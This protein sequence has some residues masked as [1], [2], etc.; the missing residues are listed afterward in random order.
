[1]CGIAGILSGPSAPPPALDQ[2]HD[3]AAMLGHRGPDGYGLYR[4]AQVGLA[5][6]R[7]SLI[8]L[9]GGFQPIHNGAGTTWLCFNGEI[10]NYVELRRHLTELGHQ[11]YTEGDSEVIVQCYERYGERCWEMLNGQFAFALWDSARQLLWLVRDRLGILPLHYARV[12]DHVVFA[13]E[14]KALFASGLVAPRFDPA[15]LAQVFTFW[16]ATAPQTVFESVRMV[17]PATALRFDTR[18]NE[19]EARYWQPD[20]HRLD[21]GALGRD[22][23]VAALEQQ[24][25]QSISLRLRADLP[26]G[27]YVSGGL[28]SAVIASLAK[29]QVGE[30]LETFGIG[31]DDPRF[32]ETGDQHQV[33]DFL[34]T[35]HHGFHCGGESIRDALSDVTWH[36][37]TPMLR[38][39]PVPLYLLARQVR[40]AGMR[41]VLTGEGADELLAGYT[42]FKEDQIRRFWA[43][44]PNSALRPA[45][46]NRIHHYVGGDKARSARVWQ[47]F[48]GRDLTATDHP[49]YSHLIRWHNTGWTLRLLA[50]EAGGTISVEVLMAEAERDLPSDWRDWDPLSRASWI[51]IQSFLS[52]WLLAHQGDRVAMAHGI[53]ARYPFLDPEM[54]DFCLALPKRHK[55]LGLRDKIALRRLAAQRLPPAVS[56][57]RKQPFRAPI[58]QALFGPEAKGYFDQ[59]LSDSALSDLGIV[60]PDAVRQLLRKARHQGGLLSEREEMGL[61]GVL[62]LSLLGRH[63]GRDFHLH[64]RRNRQLHERMTCHVFVDRLAQPAA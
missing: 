51:E 17:R 30:V 16:S 13:S 34:G 44:R 54:V 49:F 53:E 47:S 10:F 58:G 33:V 38:T 56:A 25:T 14:A 59:A 5:H 42:I 28:D 26:V 2:L 60:E 37:E 35:R 7:L 41:T 9:A 8:D 36:C 23:A 31:F 57:R 61:V 40:Q 29:D 11:F 62:T 46:L 18:L 50:P 12:G 15:G 63:F 6:T 52:S 20:P 22:E 27:A 48:F 43:R 45:L 19:R 24:L 32:D 3:M 39:S 4:D 64:M 1:M 21:L 55:L